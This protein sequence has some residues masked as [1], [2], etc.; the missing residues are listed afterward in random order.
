VNVNPTTPTDIDPETLRDLL[1]RDKAF[2]VDVR[3]AFEHAAERIE[4]SFLCTLS[5]F[6]ADDIRARSE[7]K[8]VVFH[9]RSGVRSMEAARRFAQGDEQ[10]FHLAGGILAWKRAGLA[11]V[12]SVGSPKIDIMRQV[13]IAAGTLVLVGVLGGVLVTPWLLV[14][15]GFVGSGLVFA[16]VTGWCGMAKLLGA[17]PW[18]RVPRRSSQSSP[19]IGPSA[20]KNQ[21][22]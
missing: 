3:E 22:V 8:R 13:Q 2:L 7:G 6:D 9:C 1:D 18:N 19:M 16:G 21:A 15:S 12:R 4:P 17:M 11:T 14:L 5:D 10:T 20:A